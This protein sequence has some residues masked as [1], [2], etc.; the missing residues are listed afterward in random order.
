MKSITLCGSTSFY[1]EMPEIRGRLT[2]L[3]FKVLTPELNDELSDYSALAQD[4]AARKKNYF[5]AR[6][7]PK[8]QQADAILVVNRKKKGIEG[9]IG[10]NVF[11]E[12]GFAF[13]FGKPIFLLTTVPEQENKE[14]ILGLLPRVINGDLGKIAL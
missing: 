9:Y 4:D 11:L 5:I 13:A 2:A 3:G 12:M 7:L 10:P 6:H 8:I 1:G 14:E